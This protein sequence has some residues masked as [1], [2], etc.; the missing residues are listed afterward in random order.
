MFWEVVN[1]N[2]FLKAT[3]GADW[4]ILVKPK[5]Q[6]IAR[7][8]A[9]KVIYQDGDVEVALRTVENKDWGANDEQM[10]R[11]V[12]KALCCNVLC[13]DSFKESVTWG[14]API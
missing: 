12:V 3:A 2:K 5:A 6:D 8:N 14:P 7:F 9:I 10:T 13:I 11:T 1:S 4:T